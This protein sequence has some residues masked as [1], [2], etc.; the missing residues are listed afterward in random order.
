L[1]RLE[2]IAGFQ[3]ATRQGEG[4]RQASVDVK[5]TDGTSKRLEI[6]ELGWADLRPAMKD[7]AIYTRIWRGLRLLSYW[8]RPSVFFRSVPV[9]NKTSVSM[10]YWLQFGAV[11]MIIWYVLLVLTTLHLGST[12]LFPSASPNGAA[13][14][15][16]L[17]MAAKLVWIIIVA[18]LGAKPVTDGIDLAWT[19]YAF[20]TDRDALRS[21]LRSRLVGMLS[22]I[23][24][25]RTRYARIV[26]LAHSFGTAVITDAL[27]SMVENRT[28][29]EELDLITMGSPLE[30]FALHDSKIQSLVDKCVKLE[31]VRSWIDFYAVEDAFC[32][33]VPLTGGDQGKFVSHRL[34]LNYTSFQ[35]AVGLAHNAYFY[36]PDVLGLLI[37]ATTNAT[38][39]RQD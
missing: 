29:L 39:L 27:G 24:A 30:F 34:S 4:V 35:S 17:D 1:K 31:M 33:K 8:A 20:I 14:W 18:L 26:I 37:P 9:K 10:Q 36:H 11:A 19:S 22:Y 28:G 7:V 15:N 12:E 21:K 6:R 2:D 3:V 25:D 23:A 16:W 32:S 38:T 13:G 5:R